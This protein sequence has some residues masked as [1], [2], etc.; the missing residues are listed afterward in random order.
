M[1]GRRQSCCCLSYSAAPAALH[2][3]HHAALPTPLS[4]SPPPPLHPDLKFGIGDGK[5]R[6][7]LFN[8]KVA[9][10]LRP[11]EVGLVML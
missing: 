3:C 2:S 1:G 7:Y 4:P 10:E 5:L 11:S 9:Q 8:W 6:Y